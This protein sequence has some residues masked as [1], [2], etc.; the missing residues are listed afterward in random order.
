MEESLDLFFFKSISVT[1]K[2]KKGLN[3]VQ[4]VVLHH[5]IHKFHCFSDLSI[6]RDVVSPI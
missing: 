5:F 4:P 1:T 6:C 3:P 2:T